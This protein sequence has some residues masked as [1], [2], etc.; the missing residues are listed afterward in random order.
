MLPFFSHFVGDTVG[1]TLLLS[2]AVMFCAFFLED[3]TTLIVGVLAADGIIPAPIAIIS[4]Y[5]GILAGGGVLYSIGRLART[6]R[7]LARYVEHKF[8]PSFRVWLEGRYA[9]V[10]F[11]G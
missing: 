5:A 8:S 11:S 1:S 2:L 4:L 7:R 3:V 9:M 6:H 10:I